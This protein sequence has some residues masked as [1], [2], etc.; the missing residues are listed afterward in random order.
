M[1]R[2]GTFRKTRETNLK[3]GASAQEDTPTQNVQGQDIE[4]TE[5]PSPDTS[6]IP[7]Q[8][9][10]SS[11]LTTDAAVALESTPESHADQ[12]TSTENGNCDVN[13]Q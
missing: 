7:E 1:G 13:E 6:D 5:S 11:G 4:V 12:S 8:P 2:K 10:I 9:Q 3:K